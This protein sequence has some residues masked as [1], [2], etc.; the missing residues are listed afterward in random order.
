MQILD[1]IFYGNTVRAWLVAATIAA[2][3]TLGLRLVVAIVARRLRSVAERTTNDIDDIAVAVIDHTKF[4]FLLFLGVWAGTR[5]LA[6]EEA[7]HWVVRLFGVITVVLQVAA[8]GGVAIRAGIRRQVRIKLEEDPGTATAMN[9]LGFILRHALW[10]ILVL[11]ALDNLGVEIGPLLAGLGVGGIAVALALQNVLGDL[12]ASLSII[13]DKPFVIGDF[14]V[15]GDKAGT[16]ENVG[17]KTTRVRS[18]SG[19]QLVFSNSDLLSSRIQNF[20]RMV[21][22]RILFTVG[23]L[24]QTPREKVARIPALIRESVESQENVRF[25]RAHFKEF[26]DSSLNFEIVYFVLSREFGDYMN[27]QQAIN[28]ELLGKFEAEN[29]EFAYPTRTLFLERG[30]SWPASPEK[31]EATA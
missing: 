6:M 13:L 11:A 9:A 10:V 27:V 25:D 20:K 24:Y 8:W 31:E 7:A 18:I 12:F 22:R 23:V 17:L 21:E 4:L 2:I 16:V 3:V 5:T 1:T 15:V 14:I 19:E 30:E 28:L 29:I 26:A